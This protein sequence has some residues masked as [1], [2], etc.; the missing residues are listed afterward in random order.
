[1][2]VKGYFFDGICSIDASKIPLVTTAACQD[3]ILSWITGNET[4]LIPC[5]R[6]GREEVLYFLRLGKITLRAVCQVLQSTLEENS[7]RQL[8]TVGGNMRML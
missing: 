1:M 2:E 6:Q 5:C 7:Q 3:D 4:G 8:M